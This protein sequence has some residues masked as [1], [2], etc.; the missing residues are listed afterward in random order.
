MT[1]STARP[2]AAATSSGNISVMDSRFLEKMLTSPASLW[3]WTRRPSY[4][5]CTPTVPSFLITASGWGR[6]QTHGGDAEVAGLAVQP[7]D[8][9]LRHAVGGRDRGHEKPLA[10]A[11]FN[12]LEEGREAALRQIGDR[13]ELVRRA[14]PVHVRQD[15]NQLV[16]ASRR[17]HLVQLR[18][19]LTELHS[20]FSY[21]ALGDNRALQACGIGAVGFKRAD[22]TKKKSS[23]GGIRTRDLSLAGRAQGA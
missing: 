22:C 11:D 9:L 3:I 6:R 4:L 19:Q 10:E 7:D 17:L 15:A 14:G 12:R 21:R 2:D 1:L 18:G 16:A 5:G 13:A 20:V 23:L 8:L